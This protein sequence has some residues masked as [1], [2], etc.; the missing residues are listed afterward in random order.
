MR[1]KKYPYSK[2]QWETELVHIFYRLPMYCGEYGD[3][4]PYLTIER[5]VNRLTGEIKTRKTNA[6]YKKEAYYVQD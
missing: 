3:R 2:S 5:K 6:N 4:R 1:P